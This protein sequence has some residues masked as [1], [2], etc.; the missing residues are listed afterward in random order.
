MQS[1]GMLKILYL[2]LVVMIISIIFI[3]YKNI[4]YHFLRGLY[5]NTD[6]TQEKMTQMSG[7]SDINAG[8]RKLTLTPGE[9]S[10]S[11]HVI[12]DNLS[13]VSISHMRAV[14]AQ[15]Q[16]IRENVTCHIYSAFWETRMP[17]REVR[18][19]GMSHP[20]LMADEIWCQLWY[21]GQSHPLTVKAIKI[22]RCIHS[23]KCRK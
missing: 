11:E 4:S 17:L 23:G 8:N 19:I 20:D 22:E 21:K 3:Y 1:K 14:S 10:G 2:A 9:S 6:Q 16:Q 18:V 12:C 7:A 13:N 15:W 5:S